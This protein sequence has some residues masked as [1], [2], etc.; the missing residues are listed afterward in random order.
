MAAHLVLASAS[1]RRRELLQQLGV[2]YL[3]D[4]AHID[5]TPQPSEAPSDYVQRVAVEKA[6]AVALRYPAPEYAVLAADTTVVVDGEVLGKPRDRADGLAL[7][8]RLSG[9]HH[10]VLTAVC[11]QHT[12]GCSIRLVQT[13]VEFVHLTRA[14]CEAYLATD[15]PW[16]KAGGYGIQGLGGAFVKALE[17]SYSN[18][19]GLPLSETW[20]LLASH[21]IATALDSALRE[22]M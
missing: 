8:S 19:V 7:L 6:R 15:E 11:L 1:P 17:G 10:R 4:P 12:A 3:C 20:Q 21:G 16:D 14:T 13:G 9:R 18:V 22:Q 5:E 2:S